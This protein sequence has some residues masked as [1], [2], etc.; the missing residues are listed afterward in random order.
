M[1][2]MACSLHELPVF[3]CEKTLSYHS[4]LNW[5]GNEAAS[6]NASSSQPVHQTLASFPG[7][8][9]WPGN[10]ATQIHSASK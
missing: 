8:S 2:S 6:F 10:E 3:M 4:G 5:H 1:V 7:L 9:E